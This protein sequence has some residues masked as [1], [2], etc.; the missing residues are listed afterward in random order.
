M[1][2]LLTQIYL[3]GRSHWNNL[4]TNSSSLFTHSAFPPAI[5][6]WHA[7][8]VKAPGKKLG[9]LKAFQ[10]GTV[11]GPH[12]LVP[13]KNTGL[14]LAHYS[15]W[16]RNIGEVSAASAGAAVSFHTTWMELPRQ[17]HS[18]FCVGLGYLPVPARRPTVPETELEFP[19]YNLIILTFLLRHSNKSWL[20]HKHMHYINICGEK[21]GTLGGLI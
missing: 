14:S 12:A 21:R 20:P 2:Q 15:N 19:F 9:A 4:F 10:L 13:I 1:F 3:E 5:F 17:H 11:R 6:L 8:D 7:H 16:Q 18:R